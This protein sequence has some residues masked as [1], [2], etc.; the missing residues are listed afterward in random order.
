MASDDHPV[1]ARPWPGGEKRIGGRAS[2]HEESEAIGSFRL[3]SAATGVSL[4]AV[5]GRSGATARGQA[6]TSA[7]M[8]PQGGNGLSVRWMAVWWAFRALALCRPLHRELM[9]N[10]W[11]DLT[12]KIPVTA[13]HQ[14]IYVERYSRCS[15]R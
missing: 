6:W 12:S 5:G 8:L 10:A 11:L 3:P 13:C 9:R 1:V 7:V 15:G 4:L 2:H 14:G